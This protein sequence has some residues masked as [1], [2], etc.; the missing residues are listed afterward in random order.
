MIESIEDVDKAIDGILT[1]VTSDEELMKSLQSSPNW[2]E[3]WMRLEMYVHRNIKRY[4]QM[5]G[6]G[7]L[8][9]DHLWIREI[10]FHEMQKRTGMDFGFCEYFEPGFRNRARAILTRDHSIDTWDYCHHGGKKLPTTCT[11]TDRDVCRFLDP[12]RGKMYDEVIE[13]LCRRMSED[14]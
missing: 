4:S 13:E 6:V 11:G 12:E 9:W 8:D 5:Y 10:F 2:R 14:F 3:R 1:D 7:L